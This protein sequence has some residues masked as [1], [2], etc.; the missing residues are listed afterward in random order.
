MSVLTLPDLVGFVGST[1]VVSQYFLSV[2]GK[3]NS[4]G[5][6]YPAFNLLGCFLIMFSLVYNFNPPSFFIEVFWSSVS[7]YGI[8]RYF[9]RGRTRASIATE[10]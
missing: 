9:V 2:Q 3:I 4:S 6:Y 10:H 1:I 5:L 7:L 8:V